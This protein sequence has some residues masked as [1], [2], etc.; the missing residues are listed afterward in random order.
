LGLL[1]IGIESGG[2]PD[3]PSAQR[4]AIAY[5]LY[6]GARGSI[7]CINFRRFAFKFPPGGKILHGVRF[8]RYGD[9]SIGMVNYGSVFCY[10]VSRFTPAQMAPA[11]VLPA[12]PKTQTEG[13][14]G[15]LSG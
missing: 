3:R 5:G 2:R 6:K 12:P 1:A 8:Y 9:F 11:L 13:L 10:L 14:S 7:L 4:Q 15:R